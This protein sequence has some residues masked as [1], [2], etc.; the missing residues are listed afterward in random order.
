MTGTKA[1]WACL[2]TLAGGVLTGG[3][4]ANELVE[5]LAERDVTP[6][7]TTR[8]RFIGSEADFGTTKVQVAVTDKETIQALW[9]LIEAAEAA[10]VWHAP[11]YRC[12]EFYTA[13]PAD[14]P[15]AVVNV[16]AADLCHV[17]GSTRYYYSPD[18][19]K[20]RGLYRCE[21]LHGLIMRHLAAEHKR[22]AAQPR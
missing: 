8:L 1:L 10:D 15:A 17:A 6:A 19:E 11:G 20:M 5:E 3:C 7:T 9:Q 13:E 4:A 2:L 16:N 12:V 18:A 21:G 22:R 14:K